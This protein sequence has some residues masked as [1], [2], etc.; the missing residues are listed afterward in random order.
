MRRCGCAGDGY[1]VVKDF[2]QRVKTMDK[3]I[4]FDTT[5]RDGE[6]SPGASLGL[7]EKVNI[8][9]Q[10]ARLGVDVIEAGFPFSSPG[11][12][13]A[14]QRISR[15]VTD[16]TICALARTVPDDIDRAWEAIK[17]ARSPRIHVFISSS[18]IHLR[19][20]ICQSRE[21]VLEN[22]AAMVAH[23]KKYVSDVEFSPMDASRSDPEF[24]YQLLKV[25]IDAGATTVNI[26]D[27]VGYSTPE[28]FGHFIRD[29][30]ENVPN[31]HRVV[32]SVHCH[33]DLGMATANSLAAIKNGARQIE[34][35]VN[36]IGERA[37]N[38][39]LEE[40]VMALRTRSDHYGV[41][42]NIN[43][44]LISQTSRMVSSYTGLL[45]PANKAVVGSNAFAHESGIHQ[46]GVLK[47]RTTFEIIDPSTVG[48]GQSEIVLGKHSGRHAVRVRLKALGYEFSPAEFQK[49]FVRF[50][51]IADTKKVVT[52]A[53]LEAIVSDSV[54]YPQEHYQMEYLSVTC[55]DHA[56]PTAT[57]RLVTPDGTR[58][59]DAALGNGPV[60]AVYQAI[61]RLVGIP[62]QLR[63]YTVHS[64]TGGL[65]AVAEVTIRIEQEGRIF[66]GRGHSTDVV[67]ASG[68]AYLSA[69]NKLISV[70][71]RLCSVPERCG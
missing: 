42:T 70:N 8:A 56:V 6:Q 32:V 68:K 31:I 24:V 61:N 38:A 18:D 66:S 23:A 21:Q 54:S 40:I 16:S 67:V 14:V 30:F 5:L 12:F 10:L 15:E 17:E 45:I 50:K 19:H 2:L 44:K 25:A 3:V 62:N 59:S 43:T 55:G 63:E 64:I 39:A 11:D 48:V 52:D 37:G 13:A 36:G 29:I 71:G 51:Q 46:D 35:T 22:T 26:P 41:D 27:T 65:D 57:V 7:V 1:A 60:D 28:E 4:I 53:D 58:L 34:C 33:D 69:L 47:E 20:A 9:R 49:V